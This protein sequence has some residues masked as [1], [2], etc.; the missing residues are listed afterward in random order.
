MQHNTTVKTWVLILATVYIFKC[1]IKYEPDDETSEPKHVVEK[2]TTNKY[3][4]TVFN[5]TN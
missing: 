5:C 4:L 3:V 2:I 1:V